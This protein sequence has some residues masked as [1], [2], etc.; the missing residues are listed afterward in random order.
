MGRRTER[1]RSYVSTQAGEATARGAEDRRLASERELRRQETMLGTEAQRTG[2]LDAISEDEIGFAGRYELD[3]GMVGTMMAQ[4]YSGGLDE[5][6]RG[7]LEQANVFMDQA[8]AAAR[9]G[10]MEAAAS[11]RSQADNILTDAGDRTGGLYPILNAEDVRAAFSYNE[12]PELVGDARLNSPMAQ[13]VGELVHQG[14]E[15]LDR[16]SKTSRDFRASLTEGATAAVRAGEEN[17]QRAIAAEA[18]GAS[19]QARN[20]GLQRG[21]AR[22]AA[23]AAHVQARVNEGFARD[24][25]SVATDA[26]GKIAQIEAHAAQTFETFSRNFAMDSVGFAQAWLTG[27]GGIREEFQGAMDNLRL[28]QSQLMNYAANRS[29]DFSSESGRLRAAS[30]ERSLDIIGTVLGTAIGGGLAV[31][32][33]RASVAAAAAAGAIGTYTGPSKVNLAQ[34]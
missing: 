20:F 12:R 9:G 27:Q 22:N 26:A 31:M 17:A 21:A 24:R 13:T 33:G 29:L 30:K 25:A 23:N 19:R 6:L 5:L 1:W 4:K 2:Q 34:Y 16:G 28:A 18:R 7:N 14:G 32:T 10:D 3:E 11:F 8:Q 15:F